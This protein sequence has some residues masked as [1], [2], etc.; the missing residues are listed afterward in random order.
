MFIL[1]LIIFFIVAV[2]VPTCNAIIGGR[3]ATSR[4]ASSYV[5]VRRQDTTDTF[6]GS[7]GG[8][9]IA[10]S[11]TGTAGHCIYG[12]NSVI[13]LFFFGGS[14]QTVPYTQTYVHPLI[15]TVAIV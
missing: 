3:D 10:L 5:G 11:W 9:L 2:A 6:P 14:V 15:S 4:E 7:C 1:K 13:H 12:A 8:Y